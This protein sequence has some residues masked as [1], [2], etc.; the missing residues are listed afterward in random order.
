[1][2][3]NVENGVMGFLHIHWGRCC[4]PLEEHKTLL[5]DKEEVDT[6]AGAV[7]CKS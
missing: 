1:M 6:E 2:Q 5:L 3:T 4:M 7:V